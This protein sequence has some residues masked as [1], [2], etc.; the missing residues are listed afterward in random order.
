MKNV[1][2]LNEEERV[3]I[4]QLLMHL[5]LKLDN[6]DHQDGGIFDKVNETTIGLLYQSG[7]KIKLSIKKE[8]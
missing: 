5:L 2:D 1:I 4:R 6:P 8:V 3:R 7:K